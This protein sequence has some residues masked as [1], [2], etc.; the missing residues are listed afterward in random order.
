MFKHFTQGAERGG[1]NILEHQAHPNTIGAGDPC[2][3][4]V[5][6]ITARLTKLEYQ[7]NW[8][9]LT[10]LELLQLHIDPA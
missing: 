1:I 7:L 4:S 5:P 6:G 9:I 8:H 2:R 10:G 3:Y